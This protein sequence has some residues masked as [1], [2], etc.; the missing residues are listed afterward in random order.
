MRACCRACV[1]AVVRACVM[2]CVLSCCCACVCVE[3]LDLAVCPR[4]VADLCVKHVPSTVPVAPRKRPGH[5]AELIEKSV[6]L[7]DLVRLHLLWGGKVVLQPAGLHAALRTVIAGVV[8]RHLVEGKASGPRVGM[9]SLC[10]C[11]TRLCLQSIVAGVPKG[12]LLNAP[13]CCAGILFNIEAI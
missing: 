2:S 5:R 11:T 10:R 1:R 9:C 7:L 8:V 12:K 3:R 6:D 4:C 13:V